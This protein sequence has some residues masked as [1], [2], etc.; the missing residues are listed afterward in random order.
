MTQGVLRVVVIRR[1]KV[2]PT[3][4][5]LRPGDVGLSLFKYSGT[6]AS[7]LI[8]DA[9]RSAGKQG[10]LGIVEISVQAF[11]RLRLRL[12]S[13]PGGTP[14]PTVNAIHAEARLPWWRQ[15]L[16]RV[17][18]VAVHDWFN[19]NVTPELAREARLIEGE[20]P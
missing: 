10:E 20:L 5:R 19:E 8:L 14:D 18:G 6:V 1:G 15:L 16:L 4:F 13:T 9:V 3:E 2:K 11:V 17:R 7:E 12:V